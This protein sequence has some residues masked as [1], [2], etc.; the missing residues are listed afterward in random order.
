M[1]KESITRGFRIALYVALPLAFVVLLYADRRQWFFYDDW[2]FL[3][4]RGIGGQPLDLFRPHNAHWSTIPILVYR[5]LYALVGIRSYVPYLLVLLVLHVG[6]AYVLWRVMLRSGADGWI[7]TA[8]A[9]VFLLLGAGYQNLAWGFQIGYI[10]PVLLGLLA[11]LVAD[12]AGGAFSKRDLVVWSLL[13]A[14]LMCS[15][16]GITMVVFLALV[17]LLRRG[18]HAA[19]ITASVP[20][21]VYLIWFLAIGRHY[22]LSDSTVNAQT[23]LLIPDFVWAGLTATVDKTTGLVGFGAVAILALL[24]WMVVR[25]SQ[26][27]ALP[28]AFAG[29]GATLAFFV[30]DGVDRTAGGSAFATTSRYLYVAAAL[31]LPIAAVV[32]SA[33]AQRLLAQQLVLVA[34]TGFAFIHGVSYLFDQTRTLGVIKQ[35]EEQQILAGAA[36]LSSGSTA[37]GAHPDETWAPDLTTRVLAIM[38][39]DG[40]VPAD[41]NISAANRLDAELALQVEGGPTPRVA[42]G[43]PVTLA[44][45]DGG[46]A[47]PAPN[48]CVITDSGTTVVTLSFEVD[49][50]V[51]VRSSTA[52]TLVARLATPTALSDPTTLATLVA[53]ANLY[54]SDVVPAAQLVLT[55]PEATTVCG[56]ILVAA[57]S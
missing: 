3:A 35:Q 24:A 46:S 39:R 12:R 1:Y 40:K 5:A 2:E 4:T 17:A 28:L 47:Q 31:L 20:T 51:S 26:A 54:V 6:T 57:T 33:L 27:T 36:L 18:W 30:L 11:G 45:S 55:L 52:G 13:V 10:A 7:A 23:L 22:L 43:S 41:G 44:V 34:L 29:A 21:L 49:G 25:R 37:I 14:G 53:G 19:L 15:G 16:I 8:L 56:N 48:G 9:L 38:L 32:M 50:W 42:Q